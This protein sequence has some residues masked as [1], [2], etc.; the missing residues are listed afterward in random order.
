MSAPDKHNPAQQAQFQKILED[1]LKSPD[2]RE[3]ADCGTKAPRWASTNIGVFVCIRCSGI[4]RSL[5]VHISKVKSVSLDKWSREQVE[6]MQQMGN[7]KANELYEAYIPESYNK[8][9]IREESFAL[10][11]WIRDKYERKKF[12]RRDGA[13][14]V[15]RKEFKERR[16]IQTR[17]EDRE[18]EGNGRVAPRE[19]SRPQIRD[20]PSRSVAAPETRS[21]PPPV[22]Q[23]VKEESKDLVSWD[24][25]AQPPK[26]AS[27]QNDLFGDFESAPPVGGQS[28]PGQSARDKNAILQLYNTPQIPQQMMY[29]M[30]PP[31]P[32]H[33]YPP[34]NY[35]LHTPG[36]MAPGYM[37]GPGVPNY[38]MGMMGPGVPMPGYNMGMPGGVYYNQ[39]GAPSPYQPTLPNNNINNFLNTGGVRM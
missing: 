35:H 34:P 22:R 29:G 24:E 38:T 11:Q 37:Y 21:V 39:P 33:A 7:K 19:S 3:C 27:P 9:R 13:E 15:T 1:L 6:F 5:G 17:E 8:G 36:G 32:Q 18:R 23:P 30:R 28:P 16:E 14:P 25:P 26:Q 20:P 10:E 12:M 2:N 4:H 31:M